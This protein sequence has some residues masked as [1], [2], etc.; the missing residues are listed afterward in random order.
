MKNKSLYI[1]VAI[2][3]VLLFS[4]AGAWGGEAETVNATV[5]EIDEEHKWFDFKT[6]EGEVVEAKMSSKRT[7]VKK[8]DKPASRHDVKEGSKVIITYVYDDD[9]NEPSKVII[10]E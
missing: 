8:G 9:K 5:V 3:A 1:G 10:V 4:L 2:I 6:D 7:V